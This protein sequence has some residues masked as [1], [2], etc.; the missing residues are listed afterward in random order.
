M[1]LNEYNYYSGDSDWEVLGEVDVAGSYEFDIL[2]VLR[3]KNDGRIVWSCD[4]GCSCPMPFE[5]HV[6][7]DWKEVTLKNLSEFEEICKKHK[8]YDYGFD[9]SLE[10]RVSSWHEP[11]LNLYKKVFDNI[12]LL[13]PQSEV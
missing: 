12:P 11:S 7:S 9:S 2:L 4:S 8:P 1:S 6:A 13:P 5:D 10:D 3:N